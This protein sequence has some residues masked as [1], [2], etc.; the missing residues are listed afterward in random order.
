MHAYG[1]SKLIFKSRLHIIYSFSE[2]FSRGP[3]ILKWRSHHFRFL[4]A[5]QRTFQ[6]AFWT[7]REALVDDMGQYQDDCGIESG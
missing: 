2:V 3:S 4:F 5:F 7:L 6:C 1:G